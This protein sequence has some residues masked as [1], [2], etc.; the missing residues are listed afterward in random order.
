M[1]LIRQI[2]LTVTWTELKSSSART[3]AAKTRK[4]WRRWDLLSSITITAP[5]IQVTDFLFDQN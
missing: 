3:R 2:A 1:N 5:P 4:T